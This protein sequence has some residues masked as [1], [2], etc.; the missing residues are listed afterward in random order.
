MNNKSRSG[1]M[2]IAG[3]YLVYLGFNLIKD[4][5]KGAESGGSIWFAVA[6]GLFILIGAAAAIMNIKR[7]LAERQEAEEIAE[8]EAEEQ[9]ETIEQS[10]EITAAEDKESEGE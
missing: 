8:N 5:M 9:M 7:L 4:V 10:E 6:G 3:G 2:V 1:L